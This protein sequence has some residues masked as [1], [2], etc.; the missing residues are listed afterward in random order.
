MLASG[1]VDIAGTDLSEL[2]AYV[3]S[4]P[5]YPS[6]LAVNNPVPSAPARVY[7]PTRVAQSGM[8]PSA[9][10]A[11]YNDLDRMHAWMSDAFPTDSR[12]EPARAAANDIPP[13]TNDQLGTRMRYEPDAPD[14]LA[15]MQVQ[16]GP[17]GPLQTAEGRADQLMLGRSILVPHCSE[18]IV[19]WSFG[20]QDP[21][22]G[23]VVW[24]GPGPAPVSPYPPLDPSGQPRSKNKPVGQVIYNSN[25]AVSPFPQVVTD[26]LIY[27]FSPQGNEACLTSYFGWTDPTF[28]PTPPANFSY[29]GPP[30]VPWPWPRM[31]RVTVTLSDPQDPTIESTFQYVFNT[32]DDPK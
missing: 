6:A 11:A 14:L 21:T 12:N 29:V 25:G 22:N 26:R 31:I 24:Y 1:L 4:S 7:Q 10:P 8:F 9:R 23:S 18:F 15:S 19:E 2:R 3:T 27:G 28:D 20:D 30:T 17:S 32:P 5:T 16:T 13:D